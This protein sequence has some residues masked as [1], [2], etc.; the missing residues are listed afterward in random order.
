MKLHRYNQFINEGI[1]SKGLELLNY[2]TVKENDKIAQK[3]LKMVYDNYNK[4]K[5]LMAVKISINSG[6][7]TL[8]YKISEDPYTQANTSGGE[9]SDYIEVKITSIN[10]TGWSSDIT[11]ARI[12]VEKNGKHL[13]GRDMDTNK[14]IESEHGIDKN[15]YGYLNI[16]QSQ[17]DKMINFFKSEYIKKYPEMSNFKAF[18]YW[19]I[20]EIDKEIKK[21]LEDR[22]KS[23]RKKHEDDRVELENKFKD[24]ID[25]NAKFDHEEINDYFIDLID[26]MNDTVLDEKPLIGIG[27][28][29]DNTFVTLTKR[30]DVN[31]FFKDGLF[32]FSKLDNIQGIKLGKIYYYLDFN[33]HDFNLHDMAEDG[34]ISGGTLNYEEIEKFVESEYHLSTDEKKNTNGTFRLVDIGDQNQNRLFRSF[35][36]KIQFV[37][38]IEQK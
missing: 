16:S 19:I 30:I 4:H 17:V 34:D 28:I 18:N 33:L 1:I 21:E 15:V 26:Y 14:T 24:F 8:W 23:S 5:N 3:Y 13:I 36:K 20:L 31:S 2:K 38:L 35:F 11:R 6:Y 37:I 12:E 25:Q 9:F 27:T 22:Y 29:I 7:T 10:E 32:Y